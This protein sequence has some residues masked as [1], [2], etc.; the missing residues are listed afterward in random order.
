MP[1]KWAVMKGSL[2]DRSSEIIRPHFSACGEVGSRSES[3]EAMTC[4]RRTKTALQIRAIRTAVVFFCLIF[5][6]AGS[7]QEPASEYQ[8]KAAFLFNFAKFVDWP[9]E[10]FSDA[11]SPI[12]IGVLGKNVFGHYLADTIRDKTVDNRHFEFKEFTSVNYITN[13]QI[14]FISP[15]VKDSLPAIVKGLRNASILTVSETDQFIKAGG[16]INFTIED[17]KIHFQISDEAARKAG[18]K[19]S[20][21]LLSLATRSH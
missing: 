7:A 13:C 21:K 2:C 4:R 16:M 3:G 14:L 18:L 20:S 10:A 17:N 19:I 5:S 11:N 12:V 15:S 8:I 1:G 9:P 6:L